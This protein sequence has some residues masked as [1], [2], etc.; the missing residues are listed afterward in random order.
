[1]NKVN[2]SMNEILTNTL[3]RTKRNAFTT[4]VTDY[5]VFISVSPASKKKST[6]VRFN[7]RY[8]WINNFNCVTFSRVE[9]NLFFIFSETDES[10]IAYAVSKKGGSISTSVS[11]INA[12]KLVDFKGYYKFKEY[13]WTKSRKPV[14]YV[15]LEDKI[16]E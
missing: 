9:N 13:D 15:S 10:G 3:R 6:I 11:G 7:Y 8:K 1:M 4:N 14:F 12:D 16:N 2:V 5:D